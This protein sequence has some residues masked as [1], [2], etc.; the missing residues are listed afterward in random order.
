VS[1]SPALVAAGRG[2]LARRRA[3]NQDS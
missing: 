2:Y 1:L 3:A